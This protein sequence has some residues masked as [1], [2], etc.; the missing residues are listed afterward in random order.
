MKDVALDDSSFCMVTLGI[1]QQRVRVKVRLR[2][3][4][5]IDV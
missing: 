1:T 4:E 2:V 3:R 5:R